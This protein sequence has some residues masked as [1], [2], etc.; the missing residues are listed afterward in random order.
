MK[1]VSATIRPYLVDDVRAALEELGRIIAIT[2]IKTYDPRPIAKHAY[3]GG[4][5]PD[6]TVTKLR[7]EVVVGVHE[8]ERA[9]ELIRASAFTGRFGDGYIY[10]IDV[11]QAIRIRTGEIDADTAS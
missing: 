6:E 9:V 10:V 8:V 1:L 11:D 2:E 3:R 7:V 5:I 4:Q